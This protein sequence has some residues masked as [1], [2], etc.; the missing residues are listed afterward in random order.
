VGVKAGARLQIFIADHRGS[1]RITAL[2][3]RHD[4]VPDGWVHA[5]SLRD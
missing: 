5:K 3:G 1:M 4:G 2:N